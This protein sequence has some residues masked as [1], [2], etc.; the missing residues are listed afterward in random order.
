MAKLTTMADRATIIACRGLVDFYYWKGQPVARAWPKKST[1]PRKAGEILSSQAFT[2][3]AV[4][5][6]A[7]DPTLMLIYRAQP[8]GTGVTWV[9]RFRALARLKSWDH[10]VQ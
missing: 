5:T 6:G 9:D 8:G 7:I 1:Q 2:A 10:V 3:A 4:I